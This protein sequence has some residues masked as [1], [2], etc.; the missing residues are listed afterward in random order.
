M[1]SG[2]SGLGRGEQCGGADRPERRI[3]LLRDA[4]H[5]YDSREGLAEKPGG[6]RQPPRGG[7]H[8]S[9]KDPFV[10]NAQDQFPRES[11]PILRLRLLQQLL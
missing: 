5:G 8:P 1:P 10:R 6:G 9:V 4:Q 7:S 11:N 2:E 3:R